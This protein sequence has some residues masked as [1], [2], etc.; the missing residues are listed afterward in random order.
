MEEK[1]REVEILNK[2]IWTLKEKDVKKWAKIMVFGWV[3]IIVLFL[4]ILITLL[5]TYGVKYKVLK[6]NIENT[7]TEEKVL[8][9]W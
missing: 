3:I 7:L 2:E 8:E 4:L 9:K 6:F 5:I 1:H